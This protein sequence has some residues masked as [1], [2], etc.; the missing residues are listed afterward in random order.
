MLRNNPLLELTGRVE[1]QIYIYFCL[2]CVM[3]SKATGKGN[4]WVVTLLS[5]PFLG[6]DPAHLKDFHKY[7]ILNFVLNQG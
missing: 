1:S 4:T 2:G 7:I 6:H 3:L 5:R